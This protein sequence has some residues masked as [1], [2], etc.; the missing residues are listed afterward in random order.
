MQIM[1]LVDVL[2]EKGNKTGEKTTLDDICNRGLWH[3]SVHAIIITHDHNIIAQKRSLDIVMNP[4]MIELSAGGAVNSGEEPLQAIMREVKEELGI[5][6]RPSEVVYINS[7]RY[8][9]HYPRLHKTSKTILHTY[10]IK[11]H[12]GVGR[13]KL[14]NKETSRL[15]FLSI[16]QAKRLVRYHRIVRLGKI[17]PFYSYW[18][19]SL[20]QA[21]KYIHP[22]VH[23]V[24]RGNIFRSRLAKE[25]LY[26]HSHGIKVVSSGVEANRAHFG[27]ISHHASILMKKHGLK[28]RQRSWVQTAQYN[29]DRST[30][31][32]FM[33]KTILSDA[34][35]ILDLSS[36][37]YLVW[38]IPDI[39]HNTPATDIAQSEQIYQKIIHNIKKFQQS[40]LYR[41]MAD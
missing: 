19:F 18:K 26:Q 40:D 34:Q 21:L 1:E 20:A 13:V 3:S 16:A 27:S 36:T 9:K 14:Q 32:I 38:D 28:N 6:V 29:I 23:F 25:Y 2:D 30:V 8:N 22:E 10:V 7:R 11:L 35:K 12:R 33:S 15:Y 39:K 24:C 17:T 5:D 41:L 31:V 4:D 37:N